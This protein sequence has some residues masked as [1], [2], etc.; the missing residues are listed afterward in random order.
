MRI[1]SGSARGTKLYTLEG[2]QTRPTLDRIRESV[3]NILQRRIKDAQVLDLF[4]GSGAIG[5]E[6]LSRGANSVIFCDQSP[7][8]IQIVEKNIEKTHFKEKSVL[9]KMDYIECLENFKD[10][11]FDFIYLDPPYDSDYTI[12]AVKKIVEYDMLNKTGNIFIETDMVK[13]IEGKL[14]DLQVTIKQIRKYGRVY[15]IIL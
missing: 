12:Q 4:A 8:A 3:F 5:L 13:Q 10:K 1:I 14:K 15:I 9:C 6:A 7:K 2:K 11:Q